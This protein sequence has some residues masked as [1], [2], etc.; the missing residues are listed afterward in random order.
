M[1][2]LR[3]IE[4]GDD[5]T[6]SSAPDFWVSLDEAQ[7]LLDAALPDLKCPIC[8]NEAFVLVRDFQLRFSPK[9]PVYASQLRVPTGFIDTVAMHCDDCGYFLFFSEDELLKRAERRK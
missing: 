1:A 6:T 7:K 5:N 3:K 8:G 2:K 9:I 4:L